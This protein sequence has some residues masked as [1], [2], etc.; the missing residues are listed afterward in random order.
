[1]RRLDIRMLGREMIAPE[2]IEKIGIIKD[3]FLTGAAL[4]GALVAIRGLNTWNR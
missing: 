4:I 3:V 2:T 1:M